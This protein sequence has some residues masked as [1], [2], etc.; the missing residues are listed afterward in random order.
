MVEGPNNSNLI[1]GKASSDK[2]F[3]L[4]SK[5]LSTS[6]LPEPLTTTIPPAIS[7]AKKFLSSIEIS[8]LNLAFLQSFSGFSYGFFGNINI[9]FSNFDTNFWFHQCQHTFFNQTNQNWFILLLVFGNFF[10]S[11]SAS[12]KISCNTSSL[13][14]KILNLVLFPIV[15]FCNLLS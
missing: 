4:S 13:V 1:A 7:L 6:I 5:V 12:S 11:A 2:I 14:D 3:N 10:N 8:T 15:D 9:L